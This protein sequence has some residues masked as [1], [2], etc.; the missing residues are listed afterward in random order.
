M[1]GRLQ[2]QNAPRH[3]FQHAH[4]DDCEVWMLLTE[5]EPPPPPPSA[6]TPHAI[7]VLFSSSYPMP[8]PNVTEVFTGL[9]SELYITKRCLNYFTS[10]KGKLGTWQCKRA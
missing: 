9:L 7:T 10:Q 8:N 5:F 4:N 6:I 2:Q 3:S 1:I